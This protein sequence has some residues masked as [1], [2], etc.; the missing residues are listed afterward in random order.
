[1]P[2]LSLRLPRDLPSP[3]ASACPLQPE[4]E[5]ALDKALSSPELNL[6]LASTDIVRG[7]AGHEVLFRAELS[8]SP[9]GRFLEAVVRRRKA[10]RRRTAQEPPLP[11]QRQGAAAL[12]APGTGPETRPR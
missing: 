6:P 8:L 3:S 10:A 2:L 9:E 4:E 7:T 5:Q 11:A 12:T 1:V